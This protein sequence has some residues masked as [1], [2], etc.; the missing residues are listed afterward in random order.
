MN[1]RKNIITVIVLALLVAATVLFYRYG[2]QYTGYKMVT[3]PNYLI[4][5]QVEEQGDDIV[6]IGRTALNIGSYAGSVMEFRDGVLYV[7][8]RFSLFGDETDFRIEYPQDGG[9]VHR[10]VLKKNETDKTIWI[11]PWEEKASR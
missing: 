1:K 11:R 7:G 5:E 4:I 3:H 2:W 6:I 9:T 10:V 8:V